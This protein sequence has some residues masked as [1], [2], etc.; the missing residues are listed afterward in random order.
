MFGNQVVAWGRWDMSLEVD[1]L[2][3]PRLRLWRIGF[4]CLRLASRSCLREVVAR[5][6]GVGRVE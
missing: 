1:V 4:A 5:Y 2:V 6:D 3:R